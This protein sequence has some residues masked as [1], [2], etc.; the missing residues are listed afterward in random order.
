MQATTLIAA[1]ALSLTVPTDGTPLELRAFHKA[2][3]GLEL[4]V[5]SEY[6]S[7]LTS[8]KMTRDGEEIDMSERMGG[9]S[10]VARE[11]V[12]R[13][14]YA[15]VEDGQPTATMREFVTLAESSERSMRGELVES[16]RTA[17]LEGV[18]LS[19]A[20]ED[21]E[22]TAEVEDG[23]A[24][25]DDRLLE[26]LTMTLGLEGLLPG[27][28]V[29][30]GSSWSVDGSGL[31]AA[32]GYNLEAQLFPMPERDPAGEGPRGRRGPRGGGP[33]EMFR[34]ASWDLEA[35]LAEE[36]VDAEG[37]ECLDIELSGEGTYELPEREFGGPGRRGERAL[38][39]DPVAL[40][41]GAANL[42]VEGQLL[43]NA[44]TL[45]PVSLEVE[46]SVHTEELT[47]RSSER[48]EMTIER[49]SEG[50]LTYSA[51]IATLPAQEE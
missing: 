51:T 46:V 29:E 35:T 19:L 6:T 2:G 4:T 14:R 3:L 42:S 5:E 16:E 7:E 36:R 48:G 31:L 41:G 9:P 33:G 39:L 38:A 24:P 20:L 47:E 22:V 30:P 18:T 40:F 11:V 17:P 28:E 10:S 50:T 37:V 8:F 34:G 15:A 45:V 12:I 25:D 27:E 49:T 44:E 13:D 21:G 26:G 1:L 23:D 43:L 32:L